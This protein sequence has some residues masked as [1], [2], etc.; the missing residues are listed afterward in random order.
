MRSLLVA[1][2][3]LAMTFPTSAQTTWYVD[4]PHCD[5]SGAGTPDDPFCTI[6]EA[7]NAASSGDLVFVRRGTYQENLVIPAME[8]EIQGDHDAEETI[9]VGSR[10]DE[11]PSLPA[12]T[13][14]AGTSLIL[15]DLTIRRSS[16]GILSDSSTVVCRG[17]RF[18]DNYGLG[19]YGKGGAVWAT[20]SHLRFHRC[21][22][23]SNTG[24]YGGALY[25]LGGSVKLRDS[26]FAGNCGALG[27]S[28]LIRGGVL[29]AS[30]CSFTPED[31][32]SIRGGAIYS[33]GSQVTLEE[34]SF[35]EFWSGEARGIVMWA[36]GSTLS[37]RSTV[38]DDNYASQGWGAI[39]LK[40]SS[41]HF[42]RCR[43]QRN[44]SGVGQL[45]GGA[46]FIRGSLNHASTF[47][48]C[49]FLDNWAA[50]GGAVLIDGATA[51]FDRCQFQGNQAFS[52]DSYGHGN[53]GAVAVW[54][55][56]VRLDH[57]VLTGN[58]A[59][60][61]SSGSAGRGGA[62]MGPATL[63]SCTL[64]G[65][66]ADSYWKD[67]SGE[68]GGAEDCVLNSCIVWQNMPDSL[69]GGSLAEWC[70]VE[71]GWPGTGNFDAD[72]RFWGAEHAD[73]RLLPGSPCI[74]A[75][76]PTQTDENGSRLDVGA[77]PFD[78]TFCGTPERYCE[79]KENSAG[80][81]PAIG[82]RGTP[83]IAGSDEFH[84]LA[85]NV[86]RQEFGIL[87][88]TTAGPAATPFLGGTLCVAPPLHRSDLLQSSGG[89]GTCDGVIDFHFSQALMEANGLDPGDR[90]YFQ[91]WYRDPQHADGTGTGLTDGLEA[92]ICLGS[93]GG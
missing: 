65:N 27:G 29:E 23:S 46:L 56:N 11:W 59:R 22:F 2:L 38:F 24:D 10:S 30:G 92:T 7:I 13:L 64:Y 87:I 25:V 43:F 35:R 32:K 9:L 77:L 76:D 12:V 54:G 66:V 21:S 75:G 90:L 45:E 49:S 14:A 53:G 83:A 81:V 70:D 40:E 28:I 31:C 39:Y 93:D 50:E 36:E 86:L 47:D 91:F 88:W 68:G 78:P 34:C 4:G 74:D 44:R 61:L 67:A 19:H 84:I 55:G 85:M 51:S 60:G 79:A 57:C 6:Q 3:L 20:E 37:V 26:S 89:A 82:W 52:S 41:S 80:C 58:R 71:G 48:D 33:V 5:E 17:C 73:F 69:A 62:V 42:E 18:E 72:P 8:L 15:G 1:S 63:Q 16:P